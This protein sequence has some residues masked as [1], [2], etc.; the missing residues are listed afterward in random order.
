MLAGHV[1]HVSH[2]EITGWAADR[3]RPDETVEVSVFVEGHKRAQFACALAPELRQNE[4]PGNRRYGF[5]FSFPAPL[6]RDTVHR[7]SVRFTAT[8]RVL[9]EGEVLLSPDGTTMMSPVR[10]DIEAEKMLRL[11]PPT[12]P[13]ETFQLFPFYERTYGLPDLLARTD[14]T[15]RK[16][17]DINYAVFGALRANVDGSGE[18]AAGYA[19]RDYMNEL[20]MSDAFQQEVLALLLNAFPEKRRLLFVRIPKCAGSDLSRHLMTRYP[21]VDQHLM[22]QS[23]TTKDALFNALHDLMR[24]LPSFDSIFVSG[25]MRLNWYLDRGLARPIDR[26]FT[27]IR[28]P[29]EIALSQANS[30][31]MRIAQDLE[32]GKINLDTQQWLDHLGFD[33]MPRWPL[34]DLVEHVCHKTLRTREIVIANPLCHW[35]GGGDAA[36]VLERLAASG[37]EVTETTRY[38]RWLL[39]TWGLEST[40]RLNESR[41]F[42]GRDALDREE[43]D[44]L[45]EIYAEDAKLFE[46]VQ[47]RL[48]G[49]GRSWLTGSQLCPTNS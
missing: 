37:A 41:K 15:A 30:V 8:G 21:S 46:L 35:L 28:H 24:A 2:N 3:E 49:S 43:L 26:L 4:L 18:C 5:R 34:A 32:S 1:D 45:S 7:I 19:S 11:P 48:A 16:T 9:D 22:E 14:F 40:T 17:R 10:N 6:R 36:T 33:E 38:N 42:I 13:R 23:W 39:E 29:V 27:I 44:Y 31:T 47:Q 12:T 20:L 25:H